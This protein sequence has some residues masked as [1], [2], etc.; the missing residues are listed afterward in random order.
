MERSAVAL[1]KAVGYENA[2]TVEYLFME[3][4]KSYAFLEL[5]PRLQVEH[6]VTENILQINL[7][8]CQLQVAMGIP[9]HR[10]FDIRKLYGRHPHGKDTIDFDFTDRMAA[11]RHC[12][13]V[14]ITAENPDAGFQPTSGKIHELHF[15]SAVDVWGYFSIDNSGSVH[16]FADSQFGHI[17]ASGTDRE[18]ARR[19]MIVALKEI[20]IRGEIRTTVEYIIKLMQSDDYVQNKIDTSWLDTRLSKFAEIEAAESAT[21]DQRI[22]VL[23]G[24]A[25]QAYKHFDRKGLE[26]VDML[27]VGHVPAKDILSQ[28]VS[29]DLIFKNIKYKTVCTHAGMGMIKITC[30]GRAENV[31]VRTLSDGGYM[32]TIRGKTHVVY[33][34]EDGSG[35]LRMTVDYK[36][37]IFTPEYDPTRLTSS[38]AGKIARLLV[39][40]GARLSAGQPYVEVEVMK[41][42]MPLKAAESGVISYLM[43]EG[44]SLS[45]GDL[46]A[47]V[48]LDNPDS[49]TQSEE[50][51][52]F[53]SEDT[54]LVSPTHPHI[55]LRN[56]SSILMSVLDGYVLFP[57]EIESAIAEFYAGLQNPLLPFYEVEEALSVMRGRIDADVISTIQNMN[58]KYCE[59]VQKGYR[60]FPAEDI[61]STLH[62]HAITLAA[63][64]KIAFQLQTANLW[65]II[66][67]YLYPVQMRILTSLLK[68]LEKYLNVEMLFDDMSFTDVVTS[69]R[70]DHSADL[71]KVLDLCR[72]HVNLSSKNVLMMLIIDGIKVIKP[73]SVSQRPTGI[74]LKLD[75]NARHLKLRL[76]DLSNLRQT[77]YSHV[78]L[79]ANL[80]V[81][82]QYTLTKEQRRQRV[83]E[84]ITTALSTGDPV[85]AGDRAVLIRKFA[86]S[87]IAIRDLLL[88][89]LRNDRD[90]QVAFIELYLQKLYQKTHRLTNITSGDALLG[91][92]NDSAVWLKFEFTSRGIDAVSLGEHEASDHIFNSYV[93]LVDLASANRLNTIICSDSEN[94][95]GPDES[96]SRA[97]FSSMGNRIGVFTVL[98]NAIELKRL[99]TSIIGQLPVGPRITPLK[100]GPVNAAYIV[101]MNGLGM[102]NE[103]TSTHLSEFLD[104]QQ[105]LLRS[106]GVRRLTFLVGQTDKGIASIFTFRE[107]SNFAE[108]KLYRH[109]EST[110]AFH[111]DLTRL[112]NFTISLVDGLQTSSGNVHLYR[113]I[114]RSG[115]GQARYFARLVSFSADIKSSDTESL[116]VEALDHLGLALGHEVTRSSRSLSSAANHIFLNIVAPDTVVQPDVYVA[117]LRRICGRY[118]QKL[119]RLAVSIVEIKLTCRLAVDA[120][121]MYVRLIASNP[122]GFVLKVDQYYEAFVNG[123]LV[124]K[125]VGPG[126]KGELDGVAT[127]APYSISQ[128][129]E[130]QR[131]EA[132]ASSDT[133]YVYDWPVLF[134]KAVKLQWENLI[135]TSKA[136]VVPPQDIF[137][138]RE[139][140]LCNEGTSNPLAAGWTFGSAESHSIVPITREAGLNDVG[141]VA[142]LMTYK[143]PEF[144]SGRDIVVI[145]NDITHKAGSFGTREDIVFFKASEYAR[146]RGIPRLYLAANSGARIGMAQSLRAMFNICWSDDTDAS[147]GFKYIYLSKENYSNLLESVGNDAAKMPVICTSIVAPDGQE[148]MAIT[149]IIGEEEDLGVENLMGSGLIAGETA[150]AYDDVFTL[151]LVV[152]RTVGIGAYLVRL[153]QRTIQ[154]TRMSPIILTGYQVRIFSSMNKFVLI[155]ALNRH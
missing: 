92:Q 41:M 116:F 153:G 5:N 25:L 55:S 23:C 56:S 109:I 27:R 102:S 70:K 93:D 146:N 9:L 63:D 120:E 28:Q 60:D 112:S 121:P 148:R 42:Y 130:S 137:T 76:N 30:N 20:D 133:L 79:A 106:H 36:T 152:G 94:E 141:M 149:D 4:T 35:F 84:A 91:E 155:L 125:F 107:K 144:P 82:E 67:Q 10:I 104:S 119:V 12:I 138:C 103:D 134:E 45:P 31:C 87:N 135:R 24:A 16:E 43:N 114:P 71:V 105:N 65:A 1:A 15:R 99:F 96:V 111:L 59:D 128:R 54:A 68:F 83:N 21:D 100:S 124:F 143:P 129:F 147:K 44:A 154:R 85:G 13:A 89:S 131:A 22:I 14:R 113:A 69:L 46:I 80:V 48:S 117:D 140:V 81:M 122:T 142:W 145:C 52:G 19:A 34:A 151:T 95:D 32:L 118:S 77:V 61:L 78:A 90:Y 101:L 98:E 66:E 11:P 110:H 88:E 132:L 126:S 38:V 75:L 37:C 29:I 108:D 51:Q 26:F 47:T 115:Q 62:K 53:L 40:D 150:R 17:F 127:N 136:S 50:F 86:E 74:P 73:P 6:P 8:A 57:S 18:S 39:D 2:G 58:L 7:P 139:L 3:D 33:S 64:K 123:R 97:D 72:S 49:V